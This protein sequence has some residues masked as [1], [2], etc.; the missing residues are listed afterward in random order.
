M[1]LQYA[2]DRMGQ[3]AAR[4]SRPEITQFF[5][6][7]PSG[8]MNQ[9]YGENVPY[10]TNQPYGGNAPYGM[11][12]PYGGNAPYGMNQPYGGNAP[13]GTNQPYG[14]N[15]PYGMNQPYGGNA[16]Y[17]M[18]QPYGGNAPYGVN[19]PYGGSPPYG[20]NQPYGGNAPYGM[21]QPYGGNV[22]YGMNQPYGGNAPYGTNQPYGGNAPYGMNQPCEADVPVPYERSLPQLYRNV[23][24]LPYVF[25][26]MRAGKKR[27]LNDDS[28]KTWLLFG[29]AGVVLLCIFAILGGLLAT[30]RSEKVDIAAIGRALTE[31][32][33]PGEDAERGT[34]IAEP[35]T[36]GTF[37]AQA[38][39]T[40][41]GGLTAFDDSGH[42]FLMTDYGV[43]RIVLNRGVYEYDDWAMVTEPGVK[44]ESMAVYG[45]NLYLA[46]GSAGMLR[47]NLDD[48]SDVEKLLDAPVF[49]FVIADDRIVYLTTPEDSAADDGCA[50]LYA[51][52]LDGSGARALSERAICGDVTGGC[53]YL[54]YAGGYLYYL[55]ADSNLCRMYADGTGKKQLVQAAK[56]GGAFHGS[57]LYYNGDAIY[58]PA[59]DEGIYAYDIPSGSLAKITE[60]DVYC[61][62]PIVFAGDALLY[63]SRGIWRQITGGRDTVYESELNDG[64]LC[65]VGS[66]DE[67][68]FCLRRPYEY[69][70]VAYRSGDVRSEKLIDVDYYTAPHT[71]APAT[72]RG[73]TGLGQTADG[74]ASYVCYFGEDYR[75]VKQE[76]W[77]DQLVYSDGERTYPLTDTEDGLPFW[78]TVLDDT[79][80]YT[81]F[82]WDIESALYRRPLSEDAEAE[83]LSPCRSDEQFYCSGGRIYFAGAD[84]F[85][86]ADSSDEEESGTIYCYDPENDE[87]IEVDDYAASRAW[88]VSGDT[89]YY[90]DVRDSAAGSLCRMK[91]DGTGRESLFSLDEYGYVVKLSAFEWE[92]ERYLTVT[93]D[94]CALYL[95]SED[96]SVRETVEEAGARLSFFDVT[97]PVYYEAGSLY[98][99]VNTGY[100][101]ARLELAGFFE[102]DDSCRTIV[103]E[104][105]LACF[106]VAGG[107]LSLQL[108]DT[109][110]TLFF[111]AETGER[112]EINE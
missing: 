43:C 4:D 74:R 75:I 9:P 10:G 5:G 26:D 37:P 24:V 20:M 41:R 88:C 78:F 40:P 66:R 101:I 106:D 1:D 109:G 52:A 28:M 87:I 21:N 111:D 14:G 81:M 8:G 89:L 85:D 93:T 73:Q 63:R 100:A 76:V 12:Q 97:W 94:D 22:P 105:N 80:Y 51:A 92:G 16:P 112:L 47:A 29:A 110:E 99:S 108:F 18:N 69:Y 7:D 23:P 65:M 13:Y 57:G 50:Q 55:D 2:Y 6:T 102:G 84:A 90:V 44:I 91:L 49:S 68:L 46:C 107:I 45:K 67:E 64:T 104:E 30:D 83:L 98:Y 3:P 72:L 11:N 103:C 35:L 77:D 60:A 86:D 25:A 59:E 82:G 31:S 15:A 61:R 53:V 27:K 95:V 70:D 96:G 71:E 36:D 54:E 48:G 38:A 58:L 42:V 19:Q 79:V 39:G 32:G 62:A 34:D 56:L 17:G 33:S